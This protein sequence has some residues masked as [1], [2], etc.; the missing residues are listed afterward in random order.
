MNSI[1]TLD[2]LRHEI[3][4][5]RQISDKQKNAIR[6]SYSAFKDSLTPVNVIMSILAELNLDK[7]FKSAVS[8]IEKVRE[9][10]RK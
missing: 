5:V 1:N 3:E 10:F 9:F 6:S 7:T 4:R 2:E 8:F